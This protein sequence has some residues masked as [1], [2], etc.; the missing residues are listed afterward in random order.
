MKFQITCERWGQILGMMGV[1]NLIQT[2]AKID[3]EAYRDED[4]DWCVQCSTT[5]ADMRG[6]LARLTGV[7]RAALSYRIWDLVEYTPADDDDDDDPDDGEDIPE[8]FDFK[9]IARESQVLKLAS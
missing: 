4:S 1:D 3:T 9:V 6:W 8:E 5:S 7:E 2:L